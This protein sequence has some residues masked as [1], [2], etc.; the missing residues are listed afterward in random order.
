MMLIIFI[1]AFFFIDFL[2][3][4]YKW[5]KLLSKYYANDILRYYGWLNSLEN[6]DVIS[7][8]KKELST[9]LE[10]RIYLEKIYAHEGNIKDCIVCYETNQHID[11]HYCPRGHEVCINCYCK[12]NTCY[13]RCG[14]KGI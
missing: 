4:I 11:M 2:N 1:E 14:K 6:N 9:D 3:F 12:T 7:N 13:Y 10:V 5:S 8:I